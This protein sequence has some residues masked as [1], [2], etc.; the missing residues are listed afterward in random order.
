MSDNTDQ[1]KQ[2]QDQPVAVTQDELKALPKK[3]ASPAVPATKAKGKGKKDKAKNKKK[4]V[5]S[6]AEFSSLGE[7][8]SIALPSA[9][10]RFD[11][12]FCFAYL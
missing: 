6:L 7:K 5:L 4:E 2:P 1:A 8:E 12:F 3:S 10:R 9:P 11:R